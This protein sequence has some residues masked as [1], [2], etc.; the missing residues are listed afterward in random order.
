[1]QFSP[2]YIWDRALKLTVWRNWEQAG[3]LHFVANGS[4]PLPSVTTA[5]NWPSLHP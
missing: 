5:I 1:M 3:F 4:Q 2:L